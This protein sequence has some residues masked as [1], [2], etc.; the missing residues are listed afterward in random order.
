[1]KLFVRGPDPDVLNTP[2]RGVST[3]GVYVCSLYIWRVRRTAAWIAAYATARAQEGTQN[4]AGG[5]LLARR[6]SKFGTNKNLGW[7]VLL[8]WLSRK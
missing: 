7:L 3:A 5:L 1:M 6:S 4:V 8:A 2:V